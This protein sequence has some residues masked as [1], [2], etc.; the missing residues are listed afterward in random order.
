[1]YYVLKYVNKEGLSIYKFAVDTQRHNNIKGKIKAETPD[2]IIDQSLLLAEVETREQAR[3]L[4]DKWAKS[5]EFLYKNHLS[6]RP[7]TSNDNN[8]E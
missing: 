5:D 8:E 7:V 1:M 4:R 3:N 6:S 2:F